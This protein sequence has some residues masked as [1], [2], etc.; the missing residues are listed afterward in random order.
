MKVEN[1]DIRNIKIE[2][3]HLTLRPFEEGDLDDLFEYSQVPGVGEAAGWKHHEKKEESEAVLNVFIKGHRTFAIVETE[4]GKVIGSIGLEPSASVYN[5]AGIGT[6]IN[7][8]GY[9]IGQNYWGKG[10]ATEA[11]RGV[12]GY[13][14][15]VLYLDAVTC[16]VF[17]GN[18][19]SKEV[20]KACGFKL[21]TEGKCASADGSLKNA[22]YY[23][24]T[25][26]QYGVE[27]SEE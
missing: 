18:E 1:I 2:T 10:Y 14:F 12:L 22:Q 27:Y 16:G 15:C 19:A 8:I 20:L 11:V 26:L 23:A 9:V 6:N 5:S 17:A 21:V 7:D 4:S 3:S 13:A 24:V 25:H